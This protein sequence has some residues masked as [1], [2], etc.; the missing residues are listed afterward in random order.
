VR[1]AKDGERFTTLDN[2]ERELTNEDLL[3]CDN[4]AKESRP[5]AIAGV[6]GGL[7]T[8]VG[9]STKNVLIESAYFLQSSI[10]RT[11]K[12]LGLQTDASRRFERGSDPNAVIH[13][14]DRA[15]MLMQS[16]AQGKVCEGV[17]DCKEHEFLPLAL[18]CR[19]TRV[20]QL[21]GTHLSVSEVENV[22]NR[23]GFSHRWDGN[24]A[25]HLKIPTYRADIH[26][27][28]DLIEEVARIYGYD[29]I[30]KSEA[31]FHA[32]L[33][34]NAPI[35][36]LE[37]EVR[38]LALAQGLQEFLTCDLIGPAML[39]IVQDDSIPPDSVIKVLNPTS[40]E[41]SILRT[42]L[43]PGLLQV[44]KYNFD[45]QNRDVLG[46]EIGRIHFKDKEQYKEQSV[47]G[48]IMSG[49]SSES[50]WERKSAEVDFYDLKGIIEN[51][52]Q[53]LG[54][55]NPIFK[56][57][58]LKTLHSGRQ[59]AIYLDTLEIGALG[60]VH[61]AICKRLDVPQRILFAEINLHDL[62]QMRRPKE[63]VQ[64]LSIFPSSE[65]DWTVTLG[66]EMPL[67]EVF[68]KIRL[69]PSKLLEEVTLLYIYQS[70]SLGKGLRNATFHF[71]YRDK[72]KTIAQDAV[73]AEH[74]RIIENINKAIKR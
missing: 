29:N 25:F 49:R 74:A 19:L 70:E 22:F 55:K 68:D 40:I 59:A 1:T 39:N 45:H 56:N 33:L 15:A 47:I 61:P 23:L 5:I 46:F 16:L 41:Q 13:A 73:D 30:P 37:N 51:L 69:I 52:L 26:E 44:V 32:S 2:R 4:G 54:I 14:L 43:L 62:Y 18:K 27:E 65:R 7:N 3:I 36:L 38:S 21:L 17:I 48:I 50:H 71:V 64:D 20:N 53:M 42:S 34:P 24:D 66:Q 67:Q 9:D 63:K 8:E 58:Q 28:I 35:F 10:R 57:S 31:K 6:M 72:Q 11:S 12:R 60:E